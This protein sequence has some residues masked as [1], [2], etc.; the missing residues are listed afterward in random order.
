[1]TMRDSVTEIPAVEIPATPDPATLDPSFPTFDNSDVH[2]TN[3]NATNPLRA[4]LEVFTKPKALW[5]D[6]CRLGDYFGCNEFDVV[7]FRNAV[8]YFSFTMAVN[9]QSVVQYVTDKDGHT[10]KKNVADDVTLAYVRDNLQDARRYLPLNATT[11]AFNDLDNVGPCAFT[12]STF[13][14]MFLTILTSDIPLDACDRLR[15]AVTGI[16]TEAITEASKQAAQLYFLFFLTILALVPIY[17]AD[18]KCNNGGLFKWLNR[19]IC[20]P[21]CGGTRRSSSNPF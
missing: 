10:R 1:M 16:A 9:L 11:S 4:C 21:C 13:R 12:T 19:E 8:L 14:D 2:A 5:G 15:T 20:A 7:F 6:L 17:Y 18:K 3:C